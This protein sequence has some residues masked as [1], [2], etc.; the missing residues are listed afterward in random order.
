MSQIEKEDES[1]DEEH[2]LVDQ[3]EDILAHMLDIGSE[4]EKPKERSDSRTAS[5]FTCLSL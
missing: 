5:I 2:Q 3:Q 1:E 4:N